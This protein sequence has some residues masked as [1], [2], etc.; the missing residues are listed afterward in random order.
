MTKPQVR[1]KNT[2]EPGNG[3]QYAAQSRPEAETVLEQGW[4][5][6]VMDG[7]TMDTLRYPSGSIAE[8]KY[9]NSD[10]ELRVHDTWT[11]DTDDHPSSRQSSAIYSDGQRHD[12]DDGTAAIRTWEGGKPR[13]TVHMQNGEQHDPKP[14]VPAITAFAENGTATLTIHMQHGVIQDPAP[15]VPAHVA[16]LGNGRM[17]RSTYYTQGQSWK[18][19]DDVTIDLF[20][21]H[22]AVITTTREART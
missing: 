8:E 7:V 4:T 15:G 12:A 3:G 2:G 9:Y 10:G 1:K 13:L 17:K 16:T 20:G 14:G 5:R 21:E 11:D 19:T 6:R 18:Q 22:S